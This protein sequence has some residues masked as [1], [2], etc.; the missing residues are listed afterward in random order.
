MP[1]VYIPDPL[2]KEIEKA[3]PETSSPNDFVLQAVREKLTFVEHKEEF[4]R[5]SE[6]T[7]AAMLEKNLSETDILTDF[8]CFRKKLNG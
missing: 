5:L 3:L 2:F 8:D 4:R 1:Q 6:L 7:R